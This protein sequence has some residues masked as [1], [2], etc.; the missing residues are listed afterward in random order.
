MSSGNKQTENMHQKVAESY[1]A[2][3]AKESLKCEWGPFRTLGCPL[4]A[5]PKTHVQALFGSLGCSCHT[6]APRWRVGGWAW[7]K[8]GADMSPADWQARHLHIILPAFLILLPSVANKLQM[9][10]VAYV[11]CACRPR[12]ERL[13]QVWGGEACLRVRLLPMSPHVITL[14]HLI[15]RR[16]K[17]Q[18]AFLAYKA[19]KK[20]EASSWFLRPQGASACTASFVQPRPRRHCRCCMGVLVKSAVCG[21]LDTLCVCVCLC[22][23]R[24]GTSVGL[25]SGPSEATL[26]SEH[27]T[28]STEAAAALWGSTAR[29]AAADTRLLN[30][31]IPSRCRALVG[32]H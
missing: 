23:F 7:W 17:C 19:C 24:P 14:H 8:E 12:S 31:L 18:D 29:P 25:R 6:S 11:C 22:R 13:R 21:A 20:E 9:H 32:G 5:A 2:E 10:K 16:S 3:K 26:S 27:S 1:C 15:L 30:P 28:S 4:P